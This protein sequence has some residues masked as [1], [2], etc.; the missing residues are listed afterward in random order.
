M[1][2][3]VA[4]MQGQSLADAMNNGNP[5]DNSMRGSNILSTPSSKAGRDEEED[6]QWWLMCTIEFLNIHSIL[7]FVTN[8]PQ[9]SI[10]LVESC[11][12]PLVLDSLGLVD[13]NL[14]RL[15]LLTFLHHWDA[16][17]FNRLHVVLKWHV[18]TFWWLLRLLHLSLRRL[19]LS[20]HWSICFTLFSV[21]FGNIFL[22][23]DRVVLGRRTY[24]N[25]YRYWHPVILCSIIVIIVVPASNIRTLCRLLILNVLLTLMRCMRVA[26]Q[27][28][29]HFVRRIDTVR[30]R[31]DNIPRLGVGVFILDVVD[32]LIMLVILARVIKMFITRIMIIWVSLEWHPVIRMNIFRVQMRLVLRRIGGV[33]FVYGILVPRIALLL[34]NFLV[35]R[36][37]HAFI[38]NH[39]GHTCLERISRNSRSFPPWDRRLI[40]CRAWLMSRWRVSISN[41]YGRLRIAPSY[42]RGPKHCFFVLSPHLLTLCLP[43]GDGRRFWE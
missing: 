9:N 36:V 1:Q 35:C 23:M 42:C 28:Y 3:S 26:L 12:E 24:W 34:P 39:R 38:C 8:S 30:I 11:L 27:F 25:L 18:L 41:L 4:P 13:D 33:W 19:L 20:L 32:I 16:L 5:L 2:P 37:I 17:F 7:K 6:K 15:S 31:I 29:D 22:G 43:N 21:V 10:S 40:A 14:L